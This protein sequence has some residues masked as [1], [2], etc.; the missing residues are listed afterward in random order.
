MRRAKNP[1]YF[2]EWR[3]KN[4]EKI[5]AYLAVR[6]IKRN[7]KRKEAVVSFCSRSDAQKACPHK[8]KRVYI[9]RIKRVRPSREELKERRNIRQKLYREANRERLMEGRRI[10]VNARR[11]TNL[12]FHVAESLR[13]TLRNALAR[14]I[15]GNYSRGKSKEGSAI[16]LLGCSVIEFCAYIEGKFLSGMSW[17]NYGYRGWHIDHIRPLAS[18]DLSVKEQIAE[19]VHYSNLQPLWAVD[20]LRKGDRIPTV[21]SK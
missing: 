11:K 4:R 17:D 2:K 19:A 10:Y 5:V 15:R 16:K 18:F 3:A 1:N 12:A 6:A 13:G 7:A 14:H 8:G 20:N 9:P 21:F